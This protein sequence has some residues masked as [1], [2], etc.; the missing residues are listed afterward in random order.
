MIG[1]IALVGALCVC[2]QTLAQQPGS[3]HVL[4]RVEAV[5]NNQAILAS[6]IDNELRISVLNPERGRRGP[7]TPQ[8]ALQLLI[9]RTLI[10][11]QIAQNFIQIAEPTDEEV[12]TRMK[13]MREQLPACVQK[14]CAS[15]AGWAAFLTENGLTEAKVANYTRMRMQVLG[16]IESRFR[17]GIQISRE[18]VEKYY[19]ET[20]LP[21]YPKGETVPPLDTVA[22]RIE[23]ILLEQ[24]VNALFVTWLRDLRRQG[25]VEILDRALEPTT[26]DAEGDSQ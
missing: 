4:D 11:Q 5:V 14:N 12:Q 10:E 19:R 16:F 25:G 24:R 21:Q 2:S 3:M 26:A 18:E 15:A 7:L 6:D 20:L 23:E 9:S 13:E 8:R 17:Q 22:S 1:A